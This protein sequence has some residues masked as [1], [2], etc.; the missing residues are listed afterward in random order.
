MA[1]NK[2]SKSG[3]GVTKKPA[4]V[5]HSQQQQPEK[6]TE[7]A[8]STYHVITP[9]K[10]QKRS[11]STAKGPQPKICKAAYPLY[12]PKATDIRCISESDWVQLEKAFS[13]NQCLDMYTVGDLSLELNVSDQT[14]AE[15]FEN[16]RSEARVMMQA[17]QQQQECN[18]QLLAQGVSLPTKISQASGGTKGTGQPQGQQSTGQFLTVEHLNYLEDLF[19]VG[20]H[21]PSVDCISQLAAFLTVP[22]QC[23][24]IWFHHRYD[25]W[26]E[27]QASLE[28]AI[29][30]MQQQYY[31]QLPSNSQYQQRQEL[32]STG[33]YQQR[34]ELP[35]TGQYQQRQELPSTGQYQQLPSTS[36][37]M[38]LWSEP[39]KDPRLLGK[40]PS[41]CDR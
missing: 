24:A 2:P 18:R 40:H 5:L 37:P 17:M 13:I 30:A 6:V 7:A 8:D 33:Q 14:I 32:P 9:V 4:S 11:T 39:P 26:K 34:Q 28:Y 19:R 1:T 25:A 22:Q 41:D 36:P 31:Q 16:R 38:L 3:K 21:C 15:W 10:A 20:L 29:Q 23:L 27:E 35:S 12:Q